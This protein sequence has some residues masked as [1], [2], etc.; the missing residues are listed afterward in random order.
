MEPLTCTVGR[1]RKRKNKKKSFGVNNR[2]K[3]GLNEDEKHLKNK[4]PKIPN[5]VQPN[6]VF[7]KQSMA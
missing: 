4:L 7:R 6:T 2:K 3:K 1:K 5:V